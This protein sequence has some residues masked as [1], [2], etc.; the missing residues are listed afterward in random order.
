MSGSSRM[1]IARILQ[2]IWRL[3][4]LLEPLWAVRSSSEHLQ[5]SRLGASGDALGLSWGALGLS[6]GGS[7]GVLGAS[8][9]EHSP[10]V[11]TRLVYMFSNRALHEGFYPGPLPSFRGYAYFPSA[12]LPARARVPAPG[13]ALFSIRTAASTRSRACTWRCAAPSGVRAMNH[14][15]HLVQT[16]PG[17]DRQLAAQSSRCGTL[18][19]LLGGLLEASCGSPWASWGSLGASWG[20][21]WPY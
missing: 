8:G 13:G 18:W 1:P 12:H 3:W 14:V 19:E 7:W 6:S 5:S 9:N 21:L 20:L 2:V 16:A 17:P 4:G 15:L 10:R 11:S